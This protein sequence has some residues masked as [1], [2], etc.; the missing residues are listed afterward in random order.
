MYYS[1]VKVGDFFYANYM[2]TLAI[3][4]C[5]TTSTYVEVV[6]YRKILK[7]QKLFLVK[8]YFRNNCYLDG[9]LLFIFITILKDTIN[10][11]KVNMINLMI[12][13]LAIR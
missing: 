6:V 4:Q 11:I 5:R 3:F 12:L 1:E 8:M 13:Y 9:S 2:K 10:T 7:I